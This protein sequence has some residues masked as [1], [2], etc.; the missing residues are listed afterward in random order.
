MGDWLA[1]VI[2]GALLV[3]IFFIFSLSN[4]VERCVHLAVE[5]IAGNQR[6][7]MQQLDALT[8]SIRLLSAPGSGSA[9]SERRIA[10]RRSSIQ[11]KNVSNERRSSPGR[12][13]QD[14]IA[15]SFGL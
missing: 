1:W 11:P 10:Q 12:R 9:S 2:L 4:Q 5:I 14:R 13:L 3:I 7:I 8:A 15:G 6:K